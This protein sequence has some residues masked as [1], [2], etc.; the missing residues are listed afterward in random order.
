MGKL[1]VIAVIGATA[2]GK[3]D[4]ALSGADL[5]SGE[6]VSCDSVQIYQYADI[7]SAKPS[8]GDRQQIPHHLIDVL[9]PEVRC[10]AGM[11][12]SMATNAVQ[13]ISGRGKV[14]II[15]GGTGLYLK[16]LYLGMFEQK[17]RD[18]TYR[19][20]LNARAVN[21]GID[22]LYNELCQK[23]PDY[24]K[25]ITPT[26]TLRIIRAL[27][28][29]YVTNIPFSRLHQHNVKPD[30]EWIFVSPDRSRDEIY[31]RIEK[32][33]YYMI[34][35]GLIEETELLIRRFGN[36]LPLLEAI[37]Y[38][39]AYQYLQGISSKDIMIQQLIRDTSRFAKR[40]Q[41]LFR[42]LLKDQEVFTDFEQ[43]KDRL[44]K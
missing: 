39:H 22:V 41:T 20:I 34:D 31:Q 11:W 32:R 35:N 3:S 7:G 10:N 21:E 42:N 14:S 27:E 2:S 17:S 12:R 38:K 33:V 8:L 15:A 36:Q 9:S 19:N 23:D 13:D 24:A 37:G 26:D 43:I 29:E 25:K 28:A 30:W 16:S 18:E 4:L 5:L 1:K 44:Y 40:Q 6:I